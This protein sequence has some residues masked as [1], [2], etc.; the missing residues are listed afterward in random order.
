[1]KNASPEIKSL[2]RFLVTIVFITAKEGESTVINTSI[3]LI[4]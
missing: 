4:W 3:E 1:M 2:V